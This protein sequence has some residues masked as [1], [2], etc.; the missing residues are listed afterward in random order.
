MFGQNIETIGLSYTLCQ[1]E[2]ESTWNGS[3]DKRKAKW[4]GKY[5]RVPSGQ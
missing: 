2:N 4:T 5:K 3:S 1:N